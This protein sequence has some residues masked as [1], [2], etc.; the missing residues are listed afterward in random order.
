M[1]KGI[2]RLGH[3]T[4]SREPK[5]NRRQ[6]N[7]SAGGLPAI[8]AGTKSRDTH[9]REVEIGTY[10]IAAFNV[11]RANFKSAISFWNYALTASI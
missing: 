1:A 6:A 3:K 4:A 7:D 11:V 9:Q 8:F 5:A 2:V 10:H